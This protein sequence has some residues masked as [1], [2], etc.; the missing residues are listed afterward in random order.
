[1]KAATEA[2][3]LAGLV[4]YAHPDF[5]IRI[6]GEPNDFRFKDGTQWNLH[7]SGID[8]A[9]QSRGRESLRSPIRYGRVHHQPRWGHVCGSDRAITLNGAAVNGA[10]YKTLATSAT[11]AAGAASTTVKVEPMDDTAVEGHETVI[12]TLKDLQ[13][14]IVTQQKDSLRAVSK[15]AAP[16]IRKWS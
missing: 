16:A 9:I 3:Q 14:A 15:P 11:I 2:F 12:L 4:E 13:L 5:T 7:F 6:L 8:C 1:M 10:D